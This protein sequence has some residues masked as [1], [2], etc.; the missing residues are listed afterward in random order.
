MQYIWSCILKEKRLG[1]LLLYIYEQTMMVLATVYD[2][3]I[4]LVF[5]FR[6]MMIC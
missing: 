4:K 5:K 3:T 2:G 6:K 1:K